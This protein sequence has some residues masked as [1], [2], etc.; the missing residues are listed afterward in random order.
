MRL[1]DCFYPVAQLVVMDQDT[2][3]CLNEQKALYGEKS[4]S[5]A[6]SRT[7]ERRVAQLR[8][9]REQMQ[10]QGLTVFELNSNGSTS[11]PSGK[12]VS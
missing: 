9:S 2:T 10:R 4:G 8:G 6:R 5:E 1:L 11:G 3:S 7:F 12:T